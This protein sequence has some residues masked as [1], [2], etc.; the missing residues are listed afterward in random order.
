[1]KQSKSTV[2][3]LPALFVLSSSSFCGQNFWPPHPLHSVLQQYVHV[4]LV[5]LLFRSSSVLLAACLVIG[6]CNQWSVNWYCSCRNPSPVKPWTWRSSCQPSV[7]SPTGK[8]STCVG[9]GM[10]L[11]RTC[12]RAVG[13]LSGAPIWT[14]R[15]SQTHFVRSMLSHWHSRAMS[16]SGPWCVQVAE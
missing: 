4:L 15:R 10:V 13:M 3:H 5:F 7:T 16:C 8:F 11:A 12:G 9:V 2:D 14:E 6:A 1:M